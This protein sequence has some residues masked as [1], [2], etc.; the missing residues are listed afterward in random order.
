M[1]DSL[2]PLLNALGNSLIALICF[3]WLQTAFQLVTAALHCYLFY[4]L[5]LPYSH[6]AQAQGSRIESEIGD[7]ASK[8]VIDTVQAEVDLRVRCER[9]PFE[10]YLWVWWAW[11][12]H[13]RSPLGGVYAV[14]VGVLA[15]VAASP[16]DQFGT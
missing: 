15:I 12:A 6:L 16:S 8:T 5:S 9:P 7:E 4:V 13:R 14:L 3:A 11:W 1:P 10:G 2:R